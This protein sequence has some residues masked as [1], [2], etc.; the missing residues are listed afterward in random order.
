[1]GL[2]FF[3]PL[4]FVFTV[5]VHWIQVL[6][7][8][9]KLSENATN[10]IALVVHV[11]Y[12]SVSI[13]VSVYF[14]V[15]FV[16]SGFVNLTTMVLF[17]KGISYTHVLYSTRFYIKILNKEIEY[18]ELDFEN[19]VSNQNLKI[20]EKYKENFLEF[21]TV[22]Q[23]IYFILAPTL[24]YQLHYPRAKTIRKNVLFKRLAELIILQILQL[25]LMLEYWYPT[26]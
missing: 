16:L 22:K 18:S 12:L 25:F 4:F 10:L 2:F 24:C 3:L 26:L 8:K 15:P 17:L 23:Y 20:I 11:V 1:M 9:D 14:R 7:F 13:F 21:L 5:L 6:R 19:E